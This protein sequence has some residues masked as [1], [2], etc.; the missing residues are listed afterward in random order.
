[1]S[2]SSIILITVAV[3]LLLIGFI[4][5]FVP[6]LPGPPLAW[7]GLLAAYF[8]V[9]NEITIKL[10]VITGIVAIVITILDTIL[11]SWM[12]K[13][14]GGSKAATTGS[15]IGII[16]G[17]FVGPLGI[18]LGP[19][20]GALIGELIHT[21][22]EFGKSLKSAFGAFL[23]FLCGTGMKMV[24]VGIFIWFFVKSFNLG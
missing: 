19:F 12:T 2:I 7:G 21:D 14:T 17:L 5:T 1:M 9:Y 10:L 4:G 13:K 11:P 15:T 23:G 6:V 3:V 8:S 18:I 20:I 16:V 22:G 24:T